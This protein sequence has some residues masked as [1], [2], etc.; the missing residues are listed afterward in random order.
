MARIVCFGEAMIRLAPPR[1]LR[2]EQ[3]RSFDVEIGGAELNC[4]VGLA[5]LGHAVEW[6]S[7]LPA[8]ALGRLVRNRVREAGV[9]DRYVVE[10]EGRC[11]LNF[12]ECGAAPRPS[13]VLYDRAG[14]SASR[15]TAKTFDWPAILAGA[16]WFHVT[17]ITPALS[18][19]ALLTTKAALAAAKAA[20]AKASFDLNY[21]SKLWSAADASRVLADLIPGVDILFAS[22]QD[23]ATL[24]AVCGPDF[25]TVARG[26]H[27]RFGLGAVASLRREGD[28]TRAERIAATLV[29]GADVFESKWHDVETVDRI[30]AGDAFASGVIHGMLNDDPSRAVET[31]AAMAALKQTIPGDVPLVTV[32]EVE[33]AMAGGSVR[34]KR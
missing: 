28:G 25:P 9:G 18:A 16:D 6:V 12:F 1:G 15:V 34:V 17:G 33:A 31:G 32:C 22:T 24:F 5:R 2:I 23:A 10:G 7:A 11:G 3:A 26:L 30:G 21:R 14:S 13:E 20:G 29:R 19:S 8:T 27:S 4:G